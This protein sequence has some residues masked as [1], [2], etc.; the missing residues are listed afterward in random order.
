M[1]LTV[2]DFIKQATN[3]SIR[4]ALERKCKTFEMKH[5]PSINKTDIFPFIHSLILVD[6]FFKEI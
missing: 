2:D 1:K 5:M 6:F 4:I 3:V